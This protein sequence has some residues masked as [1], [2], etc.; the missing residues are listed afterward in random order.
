MFDDVYS[1]CDFTNNVDCGDRPYPDG[2]TSPHPPT[3]SSAISTTTSLSTTSTSTSPRSTPTISETPTTTS[4]TTSSYPQPTG[5]YPGMPN[6]VLG[7]YILLADD[8]EE[9]FHSD[10][11][12][13]PKLYPYQQQGANVLFFTFINP[14][15]MVVPEAYKKLALTRGTDAEGAVPTDTRIIFAIG[16]YSYSLAPNPWMWLTSRQLAEDMAVQVAQWRDLYNI[17]G[18]DLDIE[19]G[20]GDKKEA[21]PNLIHFIRKIKSIH[22][23]FIVSQPTYGYPQV[24]AEIDVINAS[25]NVGGT[26]NGLA[27]SIGLMVYEGTQS[28]QYVK[29]YAHGSS[30][31][32]GFPI[33]VDVT[34]SDI[35]LGCKGSANPS[36]I[37]SLARESVSQNLLGVMVWFCSVQDGLTYEQSWDC[38]GSADSSQAYIEAMQYLNNNS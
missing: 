17:D 13:E 25:W 6:K 35:L 29:N 32:E 33:E 36:D 16:G 12:W 5:S 37:M 34:S 23:D 20:A 31:W 11:D 9:G 8:T 21:G 27:D 10:A 1:D 15:T 14:E 3:T 26:S 19:A 30:Q 24:Q 2:S 4:E 22:P 28:L 7:M 18:I 38:S